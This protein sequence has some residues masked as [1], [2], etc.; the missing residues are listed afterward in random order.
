MKEALKRETAQPKPYIRTIAV[1]EINQVF[2]DSLE[3]T[4]GKL[5]LSSKAFPPW[6]VSISS[7]EETSDC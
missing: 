4:S 7:Y 5:M 3:G 6:I 1:S 2:S